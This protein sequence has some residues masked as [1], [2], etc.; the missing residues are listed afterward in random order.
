MMIVRNASQRTAKDLSE[1]LST[2]VYD[3]FFPA[4]L[5]LVPQLNEVYELELAFYESKVLDDEE[6]IRNA[7]YFA[8]VG[9]TFS[10]TLDSDIIVNNEL[11]AERGAP[12]KLRIAQV[13][14]GTVYHDRYKGT[15]V[16]DGVKIFGDM[17]RFA[18]SRRECWRL[19][20]TAPHFAIS[21][22]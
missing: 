4:H 17:L 15:T 12:V 3:H 1:I 10:G 9:D 20:M 21:A 16:G 8:R 22:C 14:V 5:E 18:I 7:A 6:I 19:L 11:L 13:E 2:S